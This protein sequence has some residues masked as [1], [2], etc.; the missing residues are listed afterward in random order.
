MTSLIRLLHTKTTTT[1]F[2]LYGWSTWEDITYSEGKAEHG[3]LKYVKRGSHFPFQ[4]HIREQSFTAFLIQES[5]AW[6]RVGWRRFV[7]L[8]TRW[9]G[10]ERWPVDSHFHPGLRVVHNF[11][12]GIVERAKRERALKSPCAR[13]GDTRRGVILTRASV[14]LALLSLRKNGGLLVVYFHPVYCLFPPLRSLVQ[15]Y[16]NS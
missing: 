15:G 5:A 7:S 3:N 1:T 6:W 11:S 8:V 4:A 9:F 12:S 2:G 13:K 16:P 10:G 14:S